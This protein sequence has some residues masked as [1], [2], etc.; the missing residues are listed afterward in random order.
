MNVFTCKW[1]CFD[2]PWSYGVLNVL[3]FGTQKKSLTATLRSINQNLENEIS[4]AQIDQS[5]PY[6]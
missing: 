5:P 4:L 1:E 3:L 6:T 2:L